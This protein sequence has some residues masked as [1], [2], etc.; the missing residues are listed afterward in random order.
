MKSV[1]GW[2]REGPKSLKTESPHLPHLG[3]LKG[4]TLR[5]VRQVLLHKYRV[6]PFQLQN[7]LTERIRQYWKH[8]LSYAVE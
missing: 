7:R 5:V 1:D 4:L 2:I 6:N 8:D 3:S